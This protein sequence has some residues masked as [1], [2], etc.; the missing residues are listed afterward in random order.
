MGMNGQLNARDQ[1]GHCG[2]EKNIFLLSGIEP[3]LSNPQHVILFR[4]NKTT[5]PVSAVTRFCHQK[6]TPQMNKNC[7][8]MEKP[9]GLRTND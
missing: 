9:S 2:D 7:S 8:E 5:L 4:Q 3:M 6:A 1:F